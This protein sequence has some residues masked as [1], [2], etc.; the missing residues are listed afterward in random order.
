MV[1]GTGYLGPFPGRTL[2]ESAF[3]PGAGGLALVVPLVVLT[4]V[5]LAALTWLAVRNVA[6]REQEH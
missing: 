1:V 2:T 3:V 5:G 6:I 4:V